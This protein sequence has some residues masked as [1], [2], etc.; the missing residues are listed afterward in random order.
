MLN[1]NNTVTASLRELATNRVTW[2][3]GFVNALLA[4]LKDDQLFV[5]AGGVG[6]HAAWIMGHVATVDDN[7]VSAMTGE[8]KR[9]PDSFRTLFGM[10]SSPTGNAADYPSR[11]ELSEAMSATRQR[12]KGWIASLDESTAFEPIPERMQRI[13]PNRIMLAVAVPSHEM[14]HAGQL[15]T[16]R[17][18]LGLPRLLQ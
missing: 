5:R 13:A 1:A 2:S 17:A 3:R 14:M 10:G 15:T 18:A 6:N 16:I 7:I 11:A 9:L 8:P 4:D 12:M